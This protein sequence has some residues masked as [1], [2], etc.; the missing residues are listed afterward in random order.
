[1][2]RQPLL[3]RRSLTHGTVRALKSAALME[4]VLLIASC[5]DG[6]SSGGPMFPSDSSTTTTTTSTTTVTP[7]PSTTSPVAPSVTPTTTAST[8]V[9]TTST[10]SS[11]TSTTT[12]TSVTTGDTSA[13]SSTGTDP[14][15]STSGDFETTSTVE[16]PTLVL[17]DAGA[18]ASA[19]DDATTDTS[20]VSP[21]GETTA[22]EVDAS[23]SDV[24]STDTVEP[25]TSSE[26]VMTS[27]PAVSSSD[28]PT[29]DDPYGPNLITNP[30]FEG[31]SLTG[32][33]EFGP[34]QVSTSSAYA[35][36]GTYSG[37]ATGRTEDTWNGI[38]T[39]LLGVAS[40]GTTYHVEAAV[41]VSVTS[42]TVKLTFVMQCGNNADTYH[43]GAT[44]V[45]SNTE[46]VV[47]EGDVTLPTCAG[48]VNQL[49]FYAEGP[50]IN[51]NIYIDDVSVRQVL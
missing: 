37:L 11:M 6:T 42:D 32:W 46:W 36:S 31:N 35:Y 43:T 29:S 39:N 10:T 38:A 17:G 41:R 47:I 50:A 24:P 27:A 14:T 44:G 25:V 7:A 12:N 23:V 15:D 22:P 30:G 49:E 4:A 18:D 34:G 40:A 13:V 21:S 3:T 2:Y 1:M 48:T 19:T 28:A 33:V 20:A 16:V 26:D 9:T 51:V 5:S 8:Q 45:A